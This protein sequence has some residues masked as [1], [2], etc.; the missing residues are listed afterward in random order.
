MNWYFWQ[1]EEIFLDMFEDEYV[2]MERKPLNVEYLMMDA[3]LLL[4]PTGTP[5]TGI[6]FYKRL[7]CGEVCLLSI[8][9]FCCTKNSLEV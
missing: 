5:F 6:E 9:F 8:Y 3:S 4:P 2:E 7:P 1:S